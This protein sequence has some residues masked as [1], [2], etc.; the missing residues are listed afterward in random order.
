MKTPREVAES[1]WAPE[2]ARRVLTVEEAEG[3]VRSI[4]Q[5]I[6]ARDAEHARELADLRDGLTQA[7]R[8]TI[9]A[10]NALSMERQEVADAFD[11]SMSVNNPKG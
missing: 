4:G 5:A 2:S 11:H 10:T 9:A 3:I 8:E 6:E 7:R 1:C